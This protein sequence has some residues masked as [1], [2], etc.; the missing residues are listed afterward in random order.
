MN[1]KNNNLVSKLGTRFGFDNNI[2]T[3]RPLEKLDHQRLGPFL[4][5]KQINVVISN[6]SFQVL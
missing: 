4:I 5:V 3:I 2:K 1:I 6:S